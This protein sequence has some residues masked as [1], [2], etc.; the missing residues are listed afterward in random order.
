M[1]CILWIAVACN[2]FESRAP[3]AFVA[4][5]HMIVMSGIGRPSFVLRHGDARLPSSL[6]HSV[7]TWFAGAHPQAVRKA[8]SDDLA[9]EDEE[10][11]D[12]LILLPELI[13][14]HILE[15]IMRGVEVD[16]G[17]TSSER[18]KRRV[19]VIR[20]EDDE[21]VFKDLI[22]PET[23]LDV[24]VT[25]FKANRGRRS[26]ETTRSIAPNKRK[27][28]LKEDGQVSDNERPHGR[29]VQFDYIEEE[30]EEEELEGWQHESDALARISKF[31]WR[32][33][34]VCE[35]L[36]RYVVRQDEAKKVLSVA[37]CDHY[38]VV[39]RC[40]ADDR[41]RE[42]EYS[43][44]NILLLGA[45][46]SGKTYVVRKLA[47]LLGVPFIKS[48]ATKFTEAGIV[49]DDAEDLVRQLVDQANGDI[50]LAQ[51][52]IIYVD[53]VDKLCH[54]EASSSINGAA[55]AGATSA[56]SRG[57]QSTFLKIMEDTDV[58]LNKMWATGIPEITL[59]GMLAS[60]SSR[61][62]SRVSTKFILFIFSG[63]F[64]ALDAKLRR[65][66][67]QRSIGFVEH[68]R[69]AAPPA[70]ACRSTTTP[71]HIPGHT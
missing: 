66:R 46:G 42:A 19:F 34:E 11:Y 26:N 55:V 65:D 43:K 5:S 28:H 32:P 68:Q 38:N 56:S 12:D 2:V 35:Y 17:R 30:V 64:T 48:D 18:K 25:D 49:G 41:E 8:A 4:P 15:A 31:D 61:E 58:L 7:R 44:P 53:E 10:E 6:E 16:S 60:S 29:P 21:K 67:E 14:E 24:E 45:S 9:T 57:V 59:G 70:R 1:R 51:Y 63:A 36:D 40:L 54:S 23:A 20:T 13:P 62:P 39:R 27:A 52:G 69:P 33:R 3:K 50:R 22:G 71:L 47:K 37:I